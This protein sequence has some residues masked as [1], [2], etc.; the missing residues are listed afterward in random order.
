[1]DVHTTH[2]VLPYK[3]DLETPNVAMMKKMMLKMH[4]TSVLPYKTIYLQHA[5]SRFFD[6]VIS[7]AVLL[8]SLKEL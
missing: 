4:F 7:V 3:M 8:N 6:I 2:R 1:M 5:V